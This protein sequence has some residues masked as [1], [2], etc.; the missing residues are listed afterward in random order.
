MKPRLLLEYVKISRNV[1][2]L[3]THT[4]LYEIFLLNL[5]ICIAN[6]GYLL[7]VNGVCA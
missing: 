1:Q 6:S 2:K 3:Q 4:A 5:G 7:C